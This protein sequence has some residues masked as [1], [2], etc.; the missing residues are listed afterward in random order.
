M[1]WE[2]KI[3]FNPEDKELIKDEIIK[4]LKADL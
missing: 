3:A 1:S 2:E 4:T